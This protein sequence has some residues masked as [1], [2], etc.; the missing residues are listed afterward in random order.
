MLTQHIN[1]FLQAGEKYYQLG[2]TPFFRKGRLEIKDIQ[3]YLCAQQKAAVQYDKILES[4]TE[5][6]IVLERPVLDLYSQTFC[7]A[8]SL[9]ALRKRTIDY[10][11]WQRMVTQSFHQHFPKIVCTL[12]LP[13]NG[14]AETSVSAERSSPWPVEGFA[15]MLQRLQESHRELMAY[16]ANGITGT[17]D[18]RKSAQILR[19]YDFYFTQVK[20]L[21]LVEHAKGHHEDSLA[22]KEAWLEAKLSAI[23]PADGHAALREITEAEANACLAAL[24]GLLPGADIFPPEKIDA[25]TM[26]SFG[27]T[28]VYQPSWLLQVLGSPYLAPGAFFAAVLSVGMLGS[29]LLAACATGGISLAAAI[30]LLGGGSVMLTA[31]A[32]AYSGGLFFAPDRSG[33]SSAP[34]AEQAEKAPSQTGESIM[35]GLFS[36]GRLVLG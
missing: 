17:E 5:I 2:Y 14:A 22:K 7:R 24:P 36:L 32:A 34:K 27:R 25:R 23:V 10:P 21:M 35:G 16:C 11:A 3:D 1:Q 30:I 13:E 18:I 12:P 26:L 4:A 9:E 33:R 29:G 31:A 8:F 19:Q 6:A 15:R 28:A 20:L